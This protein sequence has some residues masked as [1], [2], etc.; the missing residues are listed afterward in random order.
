ED[1]IPSSAG[2]IS[3]NRGRR[4]RFPFSLPPTSYSLQNRVVGENDPD[5]ISS[6]SSGDRESQGRRIAPQVEA[7][8]VPGP[9]GDFVGQNVVEAQAP[10]PQRGRFFCI[11]CR[12]F[13]FV[14]VPEGFAFRNMPRICANCR[15]QEDDDDPDLNPDLVSRRRRC[16]RPSSIRR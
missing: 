9:F 16:L 11:L 8:P 12:R 1:K 5:N 10:P 13:F 14:E 6:L 15:R 4:S 3:T 7:A 2:N